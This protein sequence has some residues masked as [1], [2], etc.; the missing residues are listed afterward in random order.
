MAKSN[1]DLL[2]LANL[3]LPTLGGRSEIKFSFNDDSIIIINSKGN[4]A[5]F[6]WQDLSEVESFCRQIGYGLTGSNYNPMNGGI[7]P[8]G[9]PKHQS[10]LSLVSLVHYKVGSHPFC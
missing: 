3:T 2:N 1:Q 7:F 9:Y 6:S 4:E 8:K 10:T 5:V